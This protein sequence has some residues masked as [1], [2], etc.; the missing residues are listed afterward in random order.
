LIVVAVVAAAAAAPASGR[1]HPRVTVVGDS[2]SA[3][4]LYVPSAQRYLHRWF[5]VKLDLKVCRRLVTASCT[6]Q[7]V[8]PT[9]ALQAIEARRTTLGRIVVVDVGYNESASSYRAG[10][11]RIMRTLKKSGVRMVV[12]VTLRE[13]GT[14]ASSYRGINGVIRAAGRRW[15]GLRVADWNAWSSGKA[16]FGGDGLHLNSAGANGLARLIRNTVFTSG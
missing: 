13:A 15:R 4:L 8:T 12:W 3:S 5:D 9:T 14:Y 7:G 1:W 6:Y 11:D 10:L 2:V 16:W